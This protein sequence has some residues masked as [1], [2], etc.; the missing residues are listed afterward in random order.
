MALTRADVVEAALAILDQY[1]IADLTMRRLA[2][3]L[4]VQ[5]GA[6]YWHMPNKQS[7]LAAV[8][9]VIV[10]QV[11]V[12]GPGA[13][14]R[15]WLAD[16]AR[17]LRR[18][19]LRHRDAAELVSTTRATGLGELDWLAPPRRRL[20]EAGVPSSDAGDAAQVLTHFVLGQTYEEQ[21][22]SQLAELGVSDPPDADASERAFG[23]GVGVIL[24]GLERSLPLAV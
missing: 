20:E 23:F 17:A 9:D 4:G 14:W 1:G 12:P 19:L 18:T 22:R 5:P 15:A 8:S 11:E 24:S 13:E 10:A 21:T 3:R 7:L 2:E 6:L 16:W